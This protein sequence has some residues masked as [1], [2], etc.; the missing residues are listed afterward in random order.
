MCKLKKTEEQMQEE[1]KYPQYLSNKPG[2]ENLFDGKSQ[3]RLARAISNHICAIDAAK[4][5][6]VSRLLGWGKES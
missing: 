2:G 3:E 5:S 6:V 1:V 4:D